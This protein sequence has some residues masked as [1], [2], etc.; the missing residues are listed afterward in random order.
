MI[1]LILCQVVAAALRHRTAGHLSALDHIREEPKGDILAEKA[2]AWPKPKIPLKLFL[3][4]KYPSLEALSPSVKANVQRTM[5]L[6]PS[7]P[8]TWF[9]D[10]ACVEYLRKL[11]RLDVVQVFYR[12]TAGKYKSDI[13]RTAYLLYEG[14]F[15]VDLDVEPQIPFDEMIDGNT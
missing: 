13:C 6:N 5:D 1:P 9:D 8:V 7:F 3:C 4:S 12:A 11:G 2:E 14:G 10:F 15:Y